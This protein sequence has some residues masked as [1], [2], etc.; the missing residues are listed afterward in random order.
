MFLG[1]LS[2]N[3]FPIRRG[4]PMRVGCGPRAMP[5]L[6]GGGAWA[7]HLFARVGPCLNT[8]IFSFGSFGSGALAWMM[9]G[10]LVIS[11][12]VSFFLVSSVTSAPILAEYLGLASAGF[13]PCIGDVMNDD[14]DNINSR[15]RRQ[16]LRFIG[17]I[18]FLS[19]ISMRNKEICVTRT[20]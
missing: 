2:P 9:C 8:A 4:V 19:L 17:I 18:D 12:L 20:A 5:G 15:G 11:D 10:T 7:R 14:V 3:G 6:G 13:F 16:L 1:V